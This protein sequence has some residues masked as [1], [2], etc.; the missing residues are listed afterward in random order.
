MGSMNE[1]A[2]GRLLIL[3][4]AVMWST[5]GFFAKSPLFVDWP[6]QTEGMPVRGPLLA[7]WRAVFATVI[8]LPFVRRPRWTPKLIPM[9]LAYA[10]MNYTFLN[11]MTLTSEA[12]AIN[13]RI[14]VVGSSRTS[15]GAIHGFV[16]DPREGVMANVN[17]R[18]V[19]S[20]G[21]VVHHAQNIDDSGQI[22]GWGRTA[23]GEIHA[24][25]LDPQ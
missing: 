4:A 15:D 24:C 11:A 9:V 1:K 7:F 20:G 12:N 25:R 21:F 5:S 14:V 23:A 17:D 2:S 19:D 22:V 16:F 13:E 6:L 10:V 3:A 8:L 18:I